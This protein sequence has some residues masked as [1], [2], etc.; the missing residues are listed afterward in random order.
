MVIQRITKED[1]LEAGVMAHIDEAIKKLD[2]LNKCITIAKKQIRELQ[3]SFDK[4]DIDKMN[5][6]GVESMR[7]I[8]TTGHNEVKV[9]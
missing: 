4:I 7:N 9:T 8:I 6:G 3:D 5:T 1:I 2:E